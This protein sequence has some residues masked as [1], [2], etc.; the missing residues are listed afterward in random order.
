ME[1][2]KLKSKTNAQAEPEGWKVILNL[3]NNVH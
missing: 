3:W 1:S 2:L